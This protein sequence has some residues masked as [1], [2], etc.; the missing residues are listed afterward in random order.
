MRQ[1][2]VSKVSQPRS[3]V[4]SSGLKSRVKSEQRQATGEDLP[5]FGVQEH[6][7]ELSSSRVEFSPDYP[8]REL[9]VSNMHIDEGSQEKLRQL[10]PVQEGSPNGPAPNEAAIIANYAGVLLDHAL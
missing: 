7:G 5:I 10:N 1:S 8:F 4:A 6:S 2:T 3:N 9:G